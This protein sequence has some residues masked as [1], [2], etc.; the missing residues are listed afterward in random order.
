MNDAH[1]HLVLNHLPIVGMLFSLIVLMVGLI[2]KNEGTQRT[3]LGLLIFVGI[4]AV[5]AS[6]SG[7]Q[8]EEMV[9]EINGVSHK[10]IHEHEEWAE[11]AEWSA[12]LTGLLAS[13][14]LFLSFKRHQLTKVMLFITLLGGFVSMALF[15]KAGTSGGVIRHPEINQTAPP[16]QESH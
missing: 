10:L 2:T 16:H 3:A 7:E 15:A 13:L 12:I 1:L 5:L 11:K 8:A 14:G 9:E 6:W 4:L